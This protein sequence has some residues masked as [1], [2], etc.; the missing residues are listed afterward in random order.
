VPVLDL[1]AAMQAERADWGAFFNDG[2]HFTPAGSQV[3]SRLLLA[4]LGDAF[5]DA[6]ALD[7]VA[8]QLP[9]WDQWGAEPAATWAAFVTTQQQQ[10]A[11]GAADAGRG[12]G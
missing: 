5:G 1:F 11:E 3:V 10:P 4:A 12:G 7:A 9:W 6:L 2:L 8:N